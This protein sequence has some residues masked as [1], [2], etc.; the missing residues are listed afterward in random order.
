MAAHLAFFA[1]PAL[2]RI[3]SIG[4]FLQPAGALAFAGLYIFWRRGRLGRFE[5]AVF[6]ASILFECGLLVRIMSLTPI[7]LFIAM[8]LAL[9]FTLTR[10]VPWVRAVCFA[11]G[12]AVVYPAFQTVRPLIWAGAVETDFIGAPVLVV[13]SLLGFKLHGTQDMPGVD[14]VS[15]TTPHPFR[16]LGLA[17][18]IS[19]IALMEHVVANTPDRVPF[20]KGET[21]RPLLTSWI[22]RFIWPGKPREETGW[23]F[24]RRYGIL[25]ADDP[26]QSINL[27]WMVEMYANFGG[28]GVILGM[29]LVGALFAFLEAFLS[30]PSMTPAETAAGTA[31][32]L[33][34]FL[35]D[36][37]FSLMTGSIPLLILAFW[38]VLAVAAK[39]PLPSV[40][41]KDRP[42]S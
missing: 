30:R 39:I 18:R 26:S 16:G 42:G 12:L 10:R 19:H 5:T 36:S 22:P 6:F 33:P 29:G 38:I 24:G 17:R 21:Y 11:V 34:L 23:A 32:I 7:L 35:Q 8:F 37:N 31:V 9:E 25:N 20:W 3:P 28:A 1:V 13:R 14:P 15:N 27:P 4:Q 2:G 40:L 41:S